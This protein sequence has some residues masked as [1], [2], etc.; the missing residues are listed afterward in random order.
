M[1]QMVKNPTRTQ[2]LCSYSLAQK[3]H[4]C[5]CFVSSLSP[6][7]ASAFVWRDYTKRNEGIGSYNVNL[8]FPGVTRGKESTCQRR[9]C[10]RLRIDLWVRKIPWRRKRQPTPV[11][12]PEKSHGQRS[13]EP[14]SIPPTLPLC[15][16]LSGGAL[17]GTS[18][19]ACSMVLQ[20]SQ[21]WQRDWAMWIRTLLVISDR[22][23]LRLT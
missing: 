8:G 22:T 13:L 19:P 11:F 3:G 9:R 6:L 10:K 20:K 5:H 12:L 15:F 16:C 4:T 14:G 23:C 17:S 18:S 1:V 21:T 7:W 2:G